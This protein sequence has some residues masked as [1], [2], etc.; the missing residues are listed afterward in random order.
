ML[1][2]PQDYRALMVVVEEELRGSRWA[3]VVRDTA[4]LRAG[5][6][7]VAVM[8]YAAVVRDAHDEHRGLLHLDLHVKGHKR[9]VVRLKALLL[10]TRA[11]VCWKM[12]PVETNWRLR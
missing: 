1:P 6:E 5:E 11:A 12:K 3:G 7:V 9:H 8:G 4:R 2:A 10:Q